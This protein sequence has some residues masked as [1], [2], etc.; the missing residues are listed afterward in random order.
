MVGTT[1]LCS[2]V[3]AGAEEAEDV[4]EEDISAMEKASNKWTGLGSG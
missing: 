4:A 3:A 2:R 1:D